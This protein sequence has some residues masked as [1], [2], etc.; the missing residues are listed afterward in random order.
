MKPTLSLCASR[1]VHP[2]R[3][4]YL[5]WPIA[6]LV[7]VL[8]LALTQ[9]IIHAQGGYPKPADLYVNDYAGLLT[10][11]DAANIR[12]IFTDL[13]R[14]TGIEAVAVTINSIRDY[15]TADETI[16]SFATHLFNT[17]GIGDRRRDNGVL[18]L[19]AVQDRKVR[20]ELGAGYG[21]TYNAAMQKVIDEQMLPNFRR[22]EY[23]RGIYGGA[24]AVVA[25][26]TGSWPPD[27][28][29]SRSG[30]THVSSDTHTALQPRSRA[31][32]VPLAAMLG[33]ALTTL[34]AATFGLRRYVRYRKRR[35]PHCQA[36]MTR[37]DEVS[38]DLYLDSGQKLEELLNSVDYDVWKCPRCG[39][40]TLH[41]Y[42][43]WLTS[44]KR[45]VRCS[46]RTVEVTRQTLVSPTYTSTGEERMIRN[47]RHCDDHSEAIVILPMLTR[48]DDS[49]SS[50]S[51]SFGGGSSSGGGASGSW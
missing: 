8:T 44:F 10:N 37:L 34:G 15:G 19:V 40:H 22:H 17:W 35:C 5:F 25:A 43:H 39:M 41:P 26:L 1:L 29:Q 31:G 38:D 9:L 14:H 24:R 23:G 18:I 45:C 36:F 7:T 50:S 2:L 28:S 3:K 12:T 32:Y 20:I 16:E 48:S 49:S 47:C 46:Y 30:F 11:E 21:N 42:N 27:L 6:A 13:K 4:C 51:D 33:G